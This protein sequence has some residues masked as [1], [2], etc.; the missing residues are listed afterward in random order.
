MSEKCKNCEQILKENKTLRKALTDTN[1]EFVEVC[2]EVLA[3][4]REL[5]VTRSI[6]FPSEPRPV[7]LIVDPNMI[8]EYPRGL[9]PHG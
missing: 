7:P 3:L 5:E 4:K 8:I 9:R 2:N 6:A 1:K